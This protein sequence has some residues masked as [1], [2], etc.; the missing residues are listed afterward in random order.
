MNKEMTKQAKLCAE[1]VG[2]EIPVQPADNTH[3]LFLCGRHLIGKEEFN[4]MNDENSSVFHGFQVIYG[5]F[6]SLQACTE[7]VQD[8]AAN[9]KYNWPAYD[10][11]HY[12]KP[13]QMH[14]LT[15]YVE[16]V[17]FINEKS[18]VFQAHHGIRKMQEMAMAAEEAKRNASKALDDAK[19]L[20]TNKKAEILSALESARNEH[21]QEL[22]EIEER[23][24]KMQSQ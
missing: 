9:K 21:L 4:Y 20:P 23:M 19:D 8:Y 13:G 22:K 5:P 15:P 14:I 3:Q 12:V 2:K 6:N 17:D 11:W 7:F 18:S 10:E 16:G 1:T 24:Q